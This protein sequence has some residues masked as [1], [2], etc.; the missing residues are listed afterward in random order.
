MTADANTTH[1]DLATI[2]K[3]V[4][5]SKIALLTT[6]SAAGA[7]HARP[8]AVQEAEFD[9]DLW[10][11]TPDPSEKTDD[12]RFN[13]QV[14]VSLQSSKGFLSIAGRAEILRDE[15]KIDEL[16]SPSAEAWFP[17]GRTDPTIALLRVNAESAEYWATDEPRVVSVFKIAKAAVTGGQPDV[18]ENRAVDLP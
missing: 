15:A 17:E 6:V 3:L 2:A 12:I 1:D 13:P 5:A 9:G 4:K 11:L 10:F 16:W 14:N 7:L 8:L 18:G